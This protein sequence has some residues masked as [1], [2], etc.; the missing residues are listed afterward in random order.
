MVENIINQF[1][2]INFLNLIRLIIKNNQFVKQLKNFAK[3]I[4]ENTYQRFFEKF[5]KNFDQI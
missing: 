1:L 4:I 5:E 2:K 3:T